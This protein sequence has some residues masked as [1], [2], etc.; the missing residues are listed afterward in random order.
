MGGKLLRGNIQ[1]EADSH[2][3]VAADLTW[4]DVEDEEPDQT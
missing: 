2:G 1:S 4:K 3:I